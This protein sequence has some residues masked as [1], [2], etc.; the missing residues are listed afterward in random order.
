MHIYMRGY[1]LNTDTTFY[2]IHIKNQGNH[3]ARLRLQ[4]L[5]FKLLI[6]STL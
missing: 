3:L 5:T 2:L 6:H 4:A 1:G